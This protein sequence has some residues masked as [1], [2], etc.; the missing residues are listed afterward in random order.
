MPDRSP[1]RTAAIPPHAMMKTI[2]SLLLAAVLM[3]LS[4]S[5]YALTL[6]VS[7]DTSTTT[8]VKIAKSAGK[9]TTL[10]VSGRSMRRPLR[11]GLR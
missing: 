11:C 4:F 7:E 8:S 1:G 5:A 3:A 10:P 2:H 9:A 6:P